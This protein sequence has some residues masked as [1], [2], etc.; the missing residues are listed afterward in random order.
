MCVYINYVYVLH[1]IFQADD[2][3]MDMARLEKEHSRREDLLRQ[4]IAHL[5]I[6]SSC[7]SLVFHTSLTI[8]VFLPLL[9]SPV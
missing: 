8:T 7:Y 1:D 5:Q 2:L 4:E 9:V 6:V 3:R